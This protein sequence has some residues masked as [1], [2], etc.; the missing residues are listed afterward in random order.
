MKKK[1]KVSQSERESKMSPE[2]RQFLDKEKEKAIAEKYGLKKNLETGEWEGKG[3]LKTAG[4]KLKG[5]GSTALGLGKH[6]AGEFNK[7]IDS[8]S[9]GKSMAD[10]FT[11]SIGDIGAGLG[12]DKTVKSAAEILTPSLRFK[13]GFLDS[14]PRLTGDKLAADSAKKQ[15]QAADKQAALLQQLLDETKAS[16]AATS[17][18]KNELKQ[19]LKG[20]KP[21][22]GSG[23]GG[24]D[25]ESK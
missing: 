2:M 23:S 6:L 22:G 5:A 10:M 24:S 18:M 21:T 7:S 11:K 12:I 14:K 25:S 9:I 15:Q 17:D 8:A 1:E 16:K 19:E 20:L 4:D 3:V 13:G